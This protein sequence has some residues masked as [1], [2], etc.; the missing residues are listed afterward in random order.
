MSKGVQPGYLRIGR[1][2]AMPGDVRANDVRPE[3]FCTLAQLSC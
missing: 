3:L 2:V 1:W